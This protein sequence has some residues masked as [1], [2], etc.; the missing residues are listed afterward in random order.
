MTREIKFRAWNVHKKEMIELGD[1]ESIFIATVS[2]TDR[3]LDFTNFHSRFRIYRY[4]IMQ[5]TGLKDKNGVE[6][7]EGDIVRYIERLLVE[8]EERI[9]AVK[10]DYANNW[11][12]YPFV[13]IGSYYK[14][15]HIYGVLNNPKECEVIGNIYSNPEL[16]NN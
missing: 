7:Y 14:N 5:F 15:N 16:L 11:S 9:T 2:A 1:L 3:D 10:N 12:I 8:P 13:N 6:I 4:E